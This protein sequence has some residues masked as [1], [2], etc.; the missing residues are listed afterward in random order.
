MKRLLG[1]LLALALA[2]PVA[3]AGPNSITVIGDAQFAGTVSIEFETNADSPWAYA[4]CVAN[5][6]TVIGTD[7]NTGEPG[8]D[9]GDL[10]Y[11]Q[12]IAAHRGADTFTLG[13]TPLWQG[14]GADCS[15]TI[16]YFHDQT[17]RFRPRATATF[18]ATG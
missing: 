5:E 17:G 3:A 13:P 16:G 10:V 18:I 7:P 11:A 2:A 14:G 4:E 8:A 1:L 6:T 12:Y 9:V 15:A